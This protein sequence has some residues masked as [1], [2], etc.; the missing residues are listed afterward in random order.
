MTRV[1]RSTICAV[2][3][4]SLSSSLAI[5]PASAAEPAPAET[6][7]AREAAC[8]ESFLHSMNLQATLVSLSDSAVNSMR[9]MVPGATGEATEARARAV[10]AKARQA[11]MDLIFPKMVAD[12]KPGMMAVFT[13]TEICAMADFY[14]TELG[15]GIVAKMPDV[16]KVN[17]TS[18]QKYVP[19]M[20]SRISEVVCAEFD[21]KGTPLEKAKPDV[22]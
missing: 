12:M 9:N 1:L 16:M 10:T 11:T 8:T 4:V 15:R 2:L 21:C 22:S 3:A 18:T 19:E 17:M 6:P 7:T 13:E 14:T 5:T 20:Q